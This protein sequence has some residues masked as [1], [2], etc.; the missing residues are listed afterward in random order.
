MRSSPIDI[1]KGLAALADAE[2][3]QGLADH[4][5]MLV[6]DEPTSAAAG[7]WQTEV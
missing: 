4:R 2:E 6:G 7:D 1:G 3:Q 5:L